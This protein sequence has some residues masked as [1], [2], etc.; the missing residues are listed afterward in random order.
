MTAARRAAVHVPF[1]RV[2]FDLAERT[3]KESGRDVRVDATFQ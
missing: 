2:R 3:V 1:D